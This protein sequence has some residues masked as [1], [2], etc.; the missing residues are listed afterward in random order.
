MRELR[1]FFQLADDYLITN[2]SVYRNAATPDDYAASVPL[3]IAFERPR[4][5]AAIRAMFVATVPHDNQDSLDLDLNLDKILTASDETGRWL[6]VS[7][8][9]NGYGLRLQI[10]DQRTTRLHEYRLQADKKDIALQIHAFDRIGL[11]RR[12]DYREFNAADRHMIVVQE[13]A[14]IQGGAP[15]SLNFSVDQTTGQTYVTS[16]EAI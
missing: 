3:H 4:G 16:V 1:R 9:V 10:F 7:V 11:S 8:A 14:F 5:V 6:L 15:Q 2:L 13:P 12:Y